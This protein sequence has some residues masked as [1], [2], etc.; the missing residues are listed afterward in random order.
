MS[1]SL[2]ERATDR[3]A[4]IADEEGELTN[5]RTALVNNKC[6]SV[7][8]RQLG[9]G[10]FALHGPFAPSGVKL[11]D[12]VVEYDKMLADC[13]EAFFGAAWNW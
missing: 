7:L 5:H 12:D 10:A 9:F 11:V 6:L 2:L 8:A 1:P 4:D 3:K 13:F